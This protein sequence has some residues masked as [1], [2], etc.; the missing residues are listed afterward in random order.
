LQR[1]DTA[2]HSLACMIA[3]SRDPSCNR[4]S[5]VGLAGVNGLALWLA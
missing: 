1:I 5:S 2:G 4:T 3:A